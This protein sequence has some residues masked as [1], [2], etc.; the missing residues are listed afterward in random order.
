MSKILS[1]RGGVKPQQTKT[2]KPACLTAALMYAG[3]RGWWV[4]PATADK[5][6]YSVESRGFDNGQPW[7]KTR[8]TKEIRAYW[9]RL[10]KAG[11]GVVMGVGS[12]VFD[13]EVDT[14]GGHS[15]LKQ[16]GATS[17]AELEAE[18]APLPPTLSFVS[19]SGSVHRLFK[20]PGGDFDVEHSTSKLGIGIDIIGDKYMSIVPPSVRP[21]KGVYKWLN[22]LPVAAA[23]AWLLVL[24]RKEERAPRKTSDGEPQASIHRLKIAMAM[25]PN[26]DVSRKEWNDVA[27]ALYAATDGSEEGFRI[28]DAWSRQSVKYHGG[29]VKKW[30]H[31]HKYPP[32]VFTAGSIFY[33]ADKAVPDW[34]CRL[35]GDAEVNARIDNFLT[36]L[37]L[38]EGKHHD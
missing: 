2:S 16:D 1:Y 17:L 25:I 18:F 23:P 29:T 15:N 12:G 10:P 22:D 24:V 8:D 19:P 37:E 36:Y 7:G 14:K 21:G 35:L 27:M 31:L 6:G 34:E 5:T 13:I 33:W 20:H 9:S 4:F 30:E 3:R 11:I 32:T 28:F 26:N 38:A